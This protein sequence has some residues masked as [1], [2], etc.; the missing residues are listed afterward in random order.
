MKYAGMAKELDYGVF[1]SGSLG[2]LSEQVSSVYISYGLTLWVRDRSGRT[3]HFTSSIS[4]LAQY[5]W[6]NK[7]YSGSIANN[8]G[9]GQGGNGIVNLY[10]DPNYQGK[11][12]PCGEG[13]INSLGFGASISS[14]QIPPGFAITVYQQPNLTGSS[15]TFTRSVSNL[16]SYFGW[17]DRIN[18]VYV[19][20]Q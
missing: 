9:G 6:D 10:A 3:Q 7:I 12:T 15:K 5:G 4:N 11:V 18:S 17:N 13:R 20:R 1:S 19:Y 2:F 14:I 8:S 16:A